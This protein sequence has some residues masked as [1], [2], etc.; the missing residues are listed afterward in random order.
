GTS[1]NPAVLSINPT[2]GSA[3]AVAVGSAKVTAT[4]GTR[5]ASATVKVIRRVSTVVLTQ[6]PASVVAART[7]QLVAVPKATDG[8]DAGELADRDIRWSVVNPAGSTP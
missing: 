1:H 6:D 8:T 7:L 2:T 4:A 5:S 3:T